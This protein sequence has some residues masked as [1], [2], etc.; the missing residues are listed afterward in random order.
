MK[1]SS[2]SSPNCQNK[3]KKNCSTSFKAFSLENVKKIE[4]IG[5]G[6][7]FLGQI[8]NSALNKPLRT[9]TDDVFILS[10]SNHKA[11]AAELK[12]AISPQRLGIIRGGVTL[13]EDERIK[14][15][16]FIKRIIPSD[17]R[18]Y[19]YLEI[20]GSDA[21]ILNKYNKSKGFLSTYGN[22]LGARDGDKLKI[23]NLEPI[24]LNQKVD[25]ENLGEY[26]YSVFKNLFMQENGIKKS[27]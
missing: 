7:K 19:S 4:E 9:L 8:L 15:P 16:I 14:Y 6:T 10:N 24:T 12:S 20:Y 18:P 25:M 26:V 27:F 11:A 1:I 3:S 22:V 13:I 5:I 2:I 23:N 17:N 21:E